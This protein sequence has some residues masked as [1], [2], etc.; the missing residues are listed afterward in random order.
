MLSRVGSRVKSSTCDMMSV[1]KKLQTGELVTAR[2]CVAGIGDAV[3]KPP[4]EHDKVRRKTK[5]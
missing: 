2:I 3:Y 4:A 5:R 1:L